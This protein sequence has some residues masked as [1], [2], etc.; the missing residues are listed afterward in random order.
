MGIYDYLD[1][2][3]LTYDELRTR[4]YNL[5]QFLPIDY[6]KMERELD[7]IYD[8]TEYD[9]HRIKKDQRR[10]E[11]TCY[12]LWC[13]TLT[14]PRAEHYTD[15]YDDF[16]E[17]ID[18]RFKFLHEKYH[19]NAYVRVLWQVDCYDPEE[20]AEEILDLG[21]RL[22]IIQYCT[23]KDEKDN[24]VIVALHTIPERTTGEIADEK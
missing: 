10:F 3:D 23:F 24:T 13:A 12:D 11:S 7:G 18:S 16:C 20:I 8:E 19:I 9:L 2:F 17:K 14:L 5:S 15:A 6:K 4:L 1:E 21:T 22:N